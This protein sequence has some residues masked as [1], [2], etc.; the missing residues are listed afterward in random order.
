MSYVN[1]ASIR[2][3]TQAEGPGKRFAVWFQGCNRRCRGCCNEQMQPLKPRMVMDVLEL[4]KVIAEAR[5]EHGIEGITLLGGEPVLQAAGAAELAEWCQK[6]SL[7]VLTF[8]GYK[9]AELQAMD[10]GAVRK[11]LDCTDILVDG[12]FI[13]ELYDTSRDWVGSMNQ[14]VIYL[15]KR[16][17]PGMEYTNGEHRIEMH[18]RK[19]RIYVN[20]WPCVQ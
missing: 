4:T 7:S 2:R 13:E 1:I 17:K 19:D 14:E 11:L 15:T 10:D 9:L 6:E 18:F 20:G 16:Y 12:P 5:D 8:S 3:C